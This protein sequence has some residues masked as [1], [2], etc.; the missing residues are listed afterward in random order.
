[1]AL[2]IVY[3]A[4]T[5]LPSVYERGIE[6]LAVI[7]AT[8]RE[9]DRNKFDFMETLLFKKIATILLNLGNIKLF[10]LIRNDPYQATCLTLYTIRSCIQ[11]Y[12]SCVSVSSTASSVYSGGSYHSWRTSHRTLLSGTA[13]LTISPEPEVIS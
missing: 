3:Q 2:N 4:T 10:C 9:T 5:K 7:I 12:I 6:M 11:S 1:M 8:K 13:T